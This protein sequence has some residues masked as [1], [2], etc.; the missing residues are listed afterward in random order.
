MTAL[1][2]PSQSLLD[3]LLPIKNQFDATDDS[4]KSR[5]IVVLIDASLKK[6]K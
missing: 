5:Y 3:Y 1:A 4:S 6:I 2:S